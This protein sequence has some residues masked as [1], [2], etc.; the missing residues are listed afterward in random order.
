[1]S[2]ETIVADD[3]PMTLCACTHPRREHSGKGEKKKCTWP[4]VFGMGRCDCVEFRAPTLMV[5]K[6]KKAKKVAA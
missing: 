6:A 4:S 1:M 5:K 3:N 2:D